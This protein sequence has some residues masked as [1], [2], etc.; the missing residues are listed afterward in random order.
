MK[1][2]ITFYKILFIK[3]FLIL[4]FS[5]W[6]ILFLLKIEQN[7]GINIF[8]PTSDTYIFEEI[9]Q[10]ERKIKIQIDQNADIFLNGRKINSMEIIKEIENEPKDVTIFLEIDE[11]LS[12]KDVINL[13]DLL[14]YHKYTEIILITK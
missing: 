14:K 12:Y 5:S 8:L 9:E 1:Y 13:I 4:I 6:M 10:K 7:K 3:I 2:K 11:N